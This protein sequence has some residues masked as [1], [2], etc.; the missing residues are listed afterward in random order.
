MIIAWDGPICHVALDIP[1]PIRAEIIQL[2]M[3]ASGLLAS[4][5][6]GFALPSLRCTF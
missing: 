1:N 2:L 6:A 4:G 3:I 5:S